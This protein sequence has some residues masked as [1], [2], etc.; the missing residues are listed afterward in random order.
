MENKCRLL[1]IASVALIAL[2]GCWVPQVVQGVQP[3]IFPSQAPV[4]TE[5]STLSLESKQVALATRMI[6][7][8]QEAAGAFEISV[9]LGAHRQ[10]LANHLYYNVKQ[11]S[12]FSQW[13]FNDGLYT[14]YNPATGT[15]YGLNFLDNQAQK[16]AFDVLGFASYGSEPLPAKDFP[17][18]VTHYQITQEHFS[19]INNDNVKLQLNGVWPG[20]IPLRGSFDT[21]LSGTGSLQK[22]S[23]F[24]DLKFSL[25]GNTRSDGAIFDGQMAFSAVINQKVY[26]GF[27]RFD[28]QGLLGSVDLE[29]NGQSVAQIIRQGQTWQVQMNQQVVASVS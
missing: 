22:N 21:A 5:I 28:R 6:T 1:A 17:A 3:Q 15:R 26:N 14:Y 4:A 11:S 2:Q 25:T 24:E 27:G 23:H 20:Q 8:A 18:S 9:D 7:L 19:A 13:F 16:P 29:Q 10:A 12:Q